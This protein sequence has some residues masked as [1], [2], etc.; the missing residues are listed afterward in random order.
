VDQSIYNGR[1]IESG[2]LARLV[3]RASVFILICAVVL[4]WLL[5]N[6]ARVESGGSV[7]MVLWFIIMAITLGALLLMWRAPARGS[8]DH[9]NNLAGNIVTIMIAAALIVILG[10]VIALFSGDK[11]D[12]LR[13]AAVS[14][15]L[16]IMNYP[17]RGHWRRG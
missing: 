16:I 12:T 3:S 5:I 11:F 15:V 2:G 1:G 13:A 6:P 14:G 17:R 10:M 9:L 7:V 8:R 4:S